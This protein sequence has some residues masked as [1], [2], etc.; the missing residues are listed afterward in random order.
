MRGQRGVG[1]AEVRE[2]TFGV[3]RVVA[4]LS[5]RDLVALCPR[6]LAL[7]RGIALL[8]GSVLEAVAMLALE[9]VNRPGDGCDD[10]EQRQKRRRD[11]RHATSVRGHRVD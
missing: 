2:G 4:R 3:S 1:T 10:P 5:P 7:T 8:E 9:P 6:L 11:S